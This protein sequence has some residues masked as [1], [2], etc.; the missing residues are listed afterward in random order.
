MHEVTNF[1]RNGVCELVLGTRTTIQ[2]E[3]SV[4]SRTSEDDIV[5]INKARL[6]AQGYTQVE[7]LDF[8]ER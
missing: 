7:S 6:V 2:L 8:R 4:F 5:V 3:P 1:I